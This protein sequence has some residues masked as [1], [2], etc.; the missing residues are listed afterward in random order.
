MPI[1]QNSPMIDLLRKGVSNDAA[2]IVAAVDC[3]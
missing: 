3:E 2:A 1:K